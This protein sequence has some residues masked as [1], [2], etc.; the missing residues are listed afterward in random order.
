M[1]TSWLASGTDAMKKVPSNELSSMPEI[2][3]FVP[4]GRFG[5]VASRYREEPPVRD[6]DE[7][8]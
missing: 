7:I 4:G 2:K 5:L 3:T 8:E 6:T 1:M